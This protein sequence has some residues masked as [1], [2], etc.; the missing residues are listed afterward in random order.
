M[1][2]KRMDAAGE[3][4]GQRRIDHAVTLDPALS[5]ERFRHDMDPEMGLAAGT[6]AGMT[7]VA[8][9]FIDNVETFRS[10][11]AG[12]LFP[13]EIL[14]EH[15]PGFRR[16]GGRRSTAVGPPSCRSACGV[17]RDTSIMSGYEI[18]LAPD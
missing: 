11:S 8:M 13:D 2:R 12:Q 17:T 4:G 16:A 6:V 1:D 7:F 18:R 15:G 5:F 10:E 14:D 3:L 9:R